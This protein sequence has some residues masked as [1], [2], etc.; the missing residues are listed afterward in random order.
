M[1]FGTVFQT[2]IVALSARYF[3]DSIDNQPNYKRTKKVH[4][5]FSVIIIIISEVSHPL[6]GVSNL[7]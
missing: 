7:I 6:M 5:R 1:S 3:V 4:M 2:V